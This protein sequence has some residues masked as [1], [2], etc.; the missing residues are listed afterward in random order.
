MWH[1][2][3]AILVVYLVIYQKYFGYYWYSKWKQK[4]TKITVHE[5]L[6]K[7]YH[8]RISFM[9]HMIHMNKNTPYIAIYMFLIIYNHIWLK[10]WRKLL[11]CKKIS[12]QFPG[13]ESIFRMWYLDMLALVCTKFCTMCACWPTCL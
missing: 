2:V 13:R 9:A 1:L 4:K 12:L 6:K 3:L 5:V 8:D 7:M 11:I 10:T